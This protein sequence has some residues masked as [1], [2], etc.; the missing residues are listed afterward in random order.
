MGTVSHQI[1]DKNFKGSQLK[2]SSLSVWVVITIYSQT[3]YLINSRNLFL[4][5]LEAGIPG[6]RMA[7]QGPVFCCRGLIISIQSRM[8]LGNSMGSLR[9]FIRAL[10]S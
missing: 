7:R 8:G 1:V 9:P 6:A 10:P 5:I 3:M 2:L 4:M